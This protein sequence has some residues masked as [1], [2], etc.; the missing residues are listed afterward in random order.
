VKKNSLGSLNPDKPVFSR[1]RASGAGWARADK[2]I[3]KT[4]KGSG[5]AG[6]DPGGQN[7]PGTGATS[8]FLQNLYY[9]VK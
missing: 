5:Y 9:S 7:A 1:A 2:N 6:P 8:H 3:K 4:K